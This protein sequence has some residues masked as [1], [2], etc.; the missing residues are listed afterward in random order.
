MIQRRMPRLPRMHT[1]EVPRRSLLTRTRMMEARRS[2]AK[3]VRA[4]VTRA[5]VVAAVA[6]VVCVLRWRDSV[7]TST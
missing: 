1:R 3:R 6:R 7:R 5:V 4:R 2:P